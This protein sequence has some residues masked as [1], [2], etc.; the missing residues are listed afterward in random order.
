M[1]IVQMPV[2]FHGQCTAVLVPKPAA[3]GWNVHTRFN[4]PRRK[5]VP[6]VVMRDALS[7]HTPN[8]ITLFLTSSV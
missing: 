5:Q 4:A 7:S 8:S 1:V 3:H 2:Y 6:Q